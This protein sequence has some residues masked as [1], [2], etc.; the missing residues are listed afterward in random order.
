MHSF[1]LIVFILLSV[2][3]G[4]LNSGVTNDSSEGN[5]ETNISLVITM[6]ETLQHGE[7]FSIE[8]TSVSC[9]SGK[10]QTII[11]SKD[12]DTLTATLNEKH[13]V[14]TKMDVEKIITFELQLRNLQIGG[15][16]TVDTYV[17]KNTVETFRT[18]D[19]TCNW[20]GYKPLLSLFQ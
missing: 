3:D 15:C 5:N 8:V 4:Q 2:F 7:Q 1:K 17:L 18:S 14:L 11:I 16:S 9:F 12:E 6:I 19:G 13:K 20:H 10:R